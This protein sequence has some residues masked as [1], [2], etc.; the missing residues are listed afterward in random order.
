MLQLACVQGANA[1][2]GIKHVYVTLTTLWKIFHYS[3]KQAESLKEVQRV[4]DLPELKIVKLSDTRW[5]AHE[6]C[7]EAV[8]P[9][10]SA[11]VCSKQHLRA[12]TLTHTNLK[13]WVS[14]ALCKPST[15]SVMY[16]LNHVL[17]QVAK[18]SRALLAE[19]IDL[20]ALTPLTPLVELMPFLTHFTMSHYLWQTGYW[21]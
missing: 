13:L 16:L 10:Y 17:P 9:S 7:V 5:L 12:D 6:L 4:L 8:K 3:P 2:S 21:N 14:R 11:I 15:V 19:T 20:T 18:L 1:T